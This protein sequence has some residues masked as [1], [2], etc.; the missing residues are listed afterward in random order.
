MAAM[1]SSSGAGRDR[2]ATEPAAISSQMSAVP[3]GLLAG[4][5]AGG[6]EG[7]E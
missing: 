6:R 7:V 5:R 4:R 2:Q 3:S 1:L